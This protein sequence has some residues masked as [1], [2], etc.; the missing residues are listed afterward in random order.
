MPSTSGARSIDSRGTVDACGPKQNSGAPNA[1]F[2]LRA[3][4]TSA[5][6]VGVVLR[7]DDERRPEA[8]AFEPVDQLLGAQLVGGLVD[9]AELDARLPQQRADA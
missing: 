9:E 7:K 5:S 3:S 4:S 8:V 1:R 2:S 6:S